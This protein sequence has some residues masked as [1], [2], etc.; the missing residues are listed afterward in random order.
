[1]AHFTVIGGHCH[2]RV[3]NATIKTLSSLLLDLTATNPELL[4]QAQKL[5]VHCRRLLSTTP[6]VV[7]G[8]H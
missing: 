1:M 5:H 2:F 4:L 7:V 6:S 3:D 8:R